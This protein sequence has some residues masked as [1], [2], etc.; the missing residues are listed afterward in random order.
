MGRTKLSPVKSARVQSSYIPGRPYRT[1]ADPAT[2]RAARSKPYQTILHP[3]R[4]TPNPGRGPYAWKSTTDLSGASGLLPHGRSAG[5][6][7]SPAPTESHVDEFAF[8]DARIFETELVTDGDWYAMPQSEQERI[9]TIAQAGESIIK[10]RFRDGSEY[11]YYS[12]DHD[13]MESIF[14]LLN[15]SSHP[16][17]VVWSNLIEPRIDYRQTAART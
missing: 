5:G 13:R 17:A 15:A 11:E 8:F 4:Y 10:I 2:R 3:G 9:M 7:W 16:G 1:T 6:A 14:D 12:T